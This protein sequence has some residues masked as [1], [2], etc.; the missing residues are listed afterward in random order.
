MFG[1]GKK[2]DFDYKVYLKAIKQQDKENSQLKAQNVLLKDEMDLINAS[3]EFTITLKDIDIVKFQS[4][5]QKRDEEIL[6]LR[7]QIE[8]LNE[9]LVE[10]DKKE[11]E[12][13]A[14]V[15]KYANARNSLNKVKLKQLRKELEAAPNGAGFGGSAMVY[16]KKTKRLTTVQ[17]TSKAQALELVSKAEKGNVDI[18]I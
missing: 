1:F 15:V 2:S 14:L 3:K 7:A 17:L 11:E 6:E 16:D 18:V 13:D 12:N 9:R 5:I 10:K 4:I 8:D